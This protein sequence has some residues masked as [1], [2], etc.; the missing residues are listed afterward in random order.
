[1]FVEAVMKAGGKECLNTL[2]SHGRR[3]LEDASM[4]S[5]TLR[6]T[7]ECVSTLIEWGAHID[8][9]NYLGR[10]A[11]HPKYCLQNSS[12]YSYFVSLGP[13]PLF[14]YAA[15]T[16]VREHLP[17]QTL[18]LPNHIVSFVKLHDPQ[19]ALARREKDYFSDKLVN[20]TICH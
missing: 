1:M 13:S 11:A 10:T 15:R 20:F 8:A 14:C 6:Q 17:Y 18:G 16:I 5:K 2:N 3:L 9:V 4:I 7:G 19:F 12:T